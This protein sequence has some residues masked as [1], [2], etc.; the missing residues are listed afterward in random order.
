MMDFGLMER[1]AFWREHLR[2]QRLIFAKSRTHTAQI[3]P[4]AQQQA[5][6][7]TAWSY[8]KLQAWWMLSLCVLAVAFGVRYQFTINLTP[9]LPYSVAIIEKGNLKLARGDI[10]AF[11]WQGGW[12]FPAKAELMK[13]VVGMPGDVVLRLPHAD[14]ERY[15][16]WH[17]V[18]TPQG[19]AMP[20]VAVRRF[21]RGHNPLPEGAVGVIPD[22]QFFM[23]GDHPDSLDSRYANPGWVRADQLV[24]KVVWAW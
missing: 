18:K 15:Y 3:A 9:S 1:L 10:A 24:G 7:L 4:P 11:T 13:R 19:V 16:A 22:Q 8:F 2:P 23:Q 12:P 21:S 14:T 5:W 20:A 17:Q 6:W